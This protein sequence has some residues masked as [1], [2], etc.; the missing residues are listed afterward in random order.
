MS[1][2]WYTD[3]DLALAAAESAGLPLFIDFWAYG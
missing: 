1:I 2:P 3:L